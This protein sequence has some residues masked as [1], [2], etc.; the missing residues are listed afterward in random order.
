M[1]ASK[2]DSGSPAL[3]ST[4]PASIASIIGSSP[5]AARLGKQMLGA[6]RSHRKGTQR[7]APGRREVL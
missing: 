6:D 7:L 2:P 3:R 4:T 1:P 5:Q